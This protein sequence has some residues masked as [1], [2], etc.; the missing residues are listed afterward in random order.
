MILGLFQ[1]W[2][3]CD[4]MTPAYLR[5][6][7][8]PCR[9]LRRRVQWDLGR[10]GQA[11]PSPPAA[12]LH[13]L[14]EA[15]MGTAFSLRHVAP[16][17][18]SFCSL[19]WS[20]SYLLW[21]FLKIYFSSGQESQSLPLCFLSYHTPEKGVAWPHWQTVSRKS[22]WARWFI[23]YCLLYPIKYFHITPVTCWSDFPIYFP[24][25][26][27]RFIQGLSHTK[28]P[29]FRCINFEEVCIRCFEYGLGMVPSWLLPNRNWCCREICGCW[30]ASCLCSLTWS[31]KPLNL[32]GSNSVLSWISSATCHFLYVKLFIWLNY[33]SLWLLLSLQT[34]MVLL[35]EWC[36]S[37]SD[38]WA[39]VACAE[40]SGWSRPRC[41]LCKGLQ[42]PY[43]W[44]FLLSSYQSR[45]D[46]VSC[47]NQISR[48]V[49]CLRQKFCGGDDVIAQGPSLGSLPG[50]DCKGSSK[51]KTWQCSFTSVLLFSFPS[52]LLKRLFLTV[53]WG[54]QSRDC[55]C[56]K[57]R[58]GSALLFYKTSC[59]G[60]LHGSSHHSVV[61]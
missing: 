14:F 2:G 24:I 55:L 32:G 17:G 3:F 61:C 36:V 49:N 22:L 35:I 19:L 11:P 37:A 46:A 41:T 15:V 20:L 1:P 30:V 10:K 33:G 51:V 9:P 56:S 8:N 16:G 43:L 4:S 52:F 48:Q 50:F 26:S 54:N 42:I 57:S 25:L 31:K 18:L 58:E 5:E 60:I 28:N 47:R 53:V 7:V 44:E 13:L 29:L 21:G 59:C 6:A 23:I 34:H 39:T 45:P 40:S 12:V 38:L 27:Q